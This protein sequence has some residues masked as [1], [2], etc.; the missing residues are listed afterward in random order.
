MDVC[1][2]VV[3]NIERISVHFQG[4]RDFLELLYFCDFTYNINRE[5]YLSVLELVTISF[6]CHRCNIVSKL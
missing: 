2:W 4:K 3:F 1:R 6:V 5:P